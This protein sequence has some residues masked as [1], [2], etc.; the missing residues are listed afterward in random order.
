MMRKQFLGR[1]VVVVALTLCGVNAFAVS[2]G[3]D[4]TIFDNRVGSTSDPVYNDWWSGGA[5]DTRVNIGEAVS[6]DQEVEPGAKVGQVWDLEGMYLNG[7]ILSLVGGHNFSTGVEG[8]TTGDIFIDIDS[9]PGIRP[10]NSTGGGFDYVIDIT[11]GTDLDNTFTYEVYAIAGLTVGNGLFGTT[12]FSES[13]PWILD[14]SYSPG[15]TSVANGSFSLTTFA[16]D[17]ALDGGTWNSGYLPTGGVHY[18]LDGFDLAFLGDTSYYLHYTIE[19]GN[20][21]LTAGLMPV[22]PEPST[23]ILVGLGLAALA[24]RRKLTKAS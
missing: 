23:Y 1:L 24:A 11:A 20:D 14:D 6:E 15:L 19:C 5:P 22:V 12:N 8:I 16:S 17:A 13:N 18:V 2:L 9:F 7:T 21:V 3:T 10:P 4:I